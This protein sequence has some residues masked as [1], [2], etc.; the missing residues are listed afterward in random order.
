MKKMLYS[1]ILSIVVVCCFSLNSFAQTG[2][3]SDTL[4]L[5]FR[6]G[7]GNNY[8]VIKTLKSNT[9]VI[10]LGEENGFYNVELQSEEQGWVN[11]KF[12]VFDPPKTI[13]IL[14][15]KQE[16][17][18]YADKID[19]LESMNQDWQNKFT[20]LES[21]FT[22]KSGELE[23]SLKSALNDKKMMNTSLSESKNAYNTLINQSKNLKKIIEENKTL[24]QENETL[25]RSLEIIKSK[26][27]GLFKVAMIKWFLAGVGVLLLGWIIGQSVSTKNRRSGGS[28]LG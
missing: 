25:S 27:K 7:P 5:T 26:N 2:W 14:Q 16:N 21:E 13:I 10:I 24:K 22:Q 11:K 19:S 20:T 18:K 15:L 17:E 8:T 9:P 1:L 12:I 28:L 4:L 23:T 6:Q 3:V